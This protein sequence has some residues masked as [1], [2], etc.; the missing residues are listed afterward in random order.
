MIFGQLR[1]KIRFGLTTCSLLLCLAM[2][3]FWIRGQSRDDEIFLNLHSHL[4]IAG[5]FPQHVNFIFFHQS[6]YQGPIVLLFR[7][8]KQVHSMPE[9]WMVRISSNIYRFEI[10]L[11]WWLLMLVGLAIPISAG[12]RIV[13]RRKAIGKGHCPVCGYDLRE[14]KERCPECGTAIAA[15]VE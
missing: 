11:P 3:F 1:A 2:I 5:S 12:S 14:S 10:S 4:L 15:H 8:A 7:N 13:A 6:D 9:F